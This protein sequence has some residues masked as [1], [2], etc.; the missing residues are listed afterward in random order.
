MGAVV[1]VATP[2]P[3]LMVIYTKAKLRLVREY[4]IEYSLKIAS[5]H[6]R[7]QSHIHVTMYVH[8]NNIIPR[9]FYPFSDPHISLPKQVGRNCYPALHFLQ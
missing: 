3:T 9:L 5:R 7:V 1:P 4:C 2:I 8:V 6:Y